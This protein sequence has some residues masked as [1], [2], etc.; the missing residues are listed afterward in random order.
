MPLKFPKHFQGTLAFRLTFWYSAIFIL[1][2]LTLSVLSYLFV[3]SSIRDNRPAIKAEL[4][5]YVSLTERDGIE[6]I[7]TASH[8][9]ANPSRR[10]SF[11]VRVVDPDDT[12][13]FLSNPWLWEQFDT[14]R[15]QDQLLE[16]QWHYYTS[17]RDGDLL[18]VASA[19]LRDKKL[20]QVGKSIQDRGDVIEHFRDTLLATIIPMVLVGLAGGAL[21]AHRALRPI[22]DLSVVARSIVD[23]GRFDTR[24]PAKDS[25]D[26]LNE[27]VTLFNQMLEKIEV[28][29][30]GMKD[31]LDNV[32]HDLRTPVTR[33]RGVAESALR[34]EGNDDVRREALA[35]CLEES[36][37]VMTMLDTLMDVSEAETGTLK[38][39]LENINVAAVIEE[40][41]ELYGYVAEEKNIK[42]CINAPNDLYLRGDRARLRQVLANLVDNAIKYTPSGGRIDI[43]ASTK[44]QEAILTVKDSG[45][46][47]PAAEL[48]RIW[49]RLYRGDK[50]R[51]Q[52][53]LGL[54]L[55]LVKAVVQAH[56]GQVEAFAN[57][58]GGSVFSVY[59][60]LLPAA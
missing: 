15:P 53:G 11:F 36:E 57:P 28:L 39:A 24:V 20:L 50:S 14:T 18:E 13:L 56:H 4:A 46:G 47:I 21:L 54:G 38:L 35:D 6:A 59:L 17:R 25:G 23:T 55:S 45:I 2:F 19:R 29:I 10:N 34:S 33:L 58:S 5:K 40:V 51:S 52:R 32:A 30:Q 1:S 31:A 3:F 7:E 37:R 42:L 60:P 8:V 43:G 12:T 26:E 22:H 9:Q 44:G 16:G 27:L 49:D 41:A 48:P